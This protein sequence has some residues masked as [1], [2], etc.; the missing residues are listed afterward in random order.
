MRRLRQVVTVRQDEVLAQRH[1]DAD[2]DVHLPRAVADAVVADLSAPGELVLDPF[3]GYGTTLRAALDA[4]RR[5]VGVEL[6]A[7]RAAIAAEVAPGAEVLTGDARDLADLVTGPV[8]LVLTSPPYMTATDHPED[9]FAGYTG[10]GATYAG[11][12]D[13]LRGMLAA[14]LDLLTP[15]GHLVVNVANIDT[16]SHFTPLAWD[17]GALL[18]E[19]GRLTQ[20]CFVV[21][22]RPWHDLAGDYLLVARP[23]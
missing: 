15:E 1:P 8:D 21:W 9:P 14:C 10:S 23:R 5:A 20:D 18:A 2:E 17:V 12:L 7:E 6:L 4:G 22:D 19:V 3:A 11:Y 13:Q 16:G